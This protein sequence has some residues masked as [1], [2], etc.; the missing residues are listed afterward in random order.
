MQPALFATTTVPLDDLRHIKFVMPVVLLAL[1]WAW[2]TRRPFFGHRPGRR[3]HASRN[4][5]VAVFNTAPL[6]PTFG[7]VT[8]AVAG[9]TENNQYGLLNILRVS[10][11][12]RF[13]LALLLLDG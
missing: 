1:F 8:A 6:G 5:A 12:I 4:L 13:A 7:L 9:W 2:E 10:A 11:P 3:R